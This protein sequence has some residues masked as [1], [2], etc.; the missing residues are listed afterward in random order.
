M[1]V[2]K[3]EKESKFVPFNE[4]KPGEFFINHR[5]NYAN[6]DYKELW[7]KVKMEEG[8]NCFSFDRQTENGYGRTCGLTFEVVK[9]TEIKYESN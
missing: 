2:T 6:P 4:I 3:L 8:G 7:L 1:K 5:L 9:V